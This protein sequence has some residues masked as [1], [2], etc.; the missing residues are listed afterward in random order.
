MK[1]FRLFL[2]VLLLVCLCAT[3][4]AAEPPFYTMT[5]DHDGEFVYSQAGYL[6]DLALYEFD[7]KPLKRPVDVFL[8]EE[9]NLF[10]ADNGNKRIIMC[11]RD[12]EYLRTYG[13]GL[14]KAPMG[15]CVR[16]GKLYVADESLKQ[17]VIFD[18]AS[19]DVIFELDKPEDLLYGQENNF[20]PQAVLVDNAG[21][22]YV[23]CKGNPNGIAQFSADGTFLC[24]FGAN[25]NKLTPMEML[26]RF[27]F[28]E[29]EA[30]RFSK[31]LS[32]S[33]VNM[34]MDER[35]MIY[36]VTGGYKG[37]KRL[38]M[39]GND[40]MPGTSQGFVG[41]T[42][43]A[44]GEYGNIFVIDQNG[45]I[46]EY[47]RDGRVLFYFAGQDAT[48]TRSG[49]FV[50]TVAIDIDS[51]G[52]LYV[53]DR[54]KGV[55]QRFAITEYARQV[56]HALSL[57]QDGLYEESREP[58]EDLLKQN[59]MFD[60]AQ[61]GLGRAYF[62]LEMYDEALTASRLGGDRNG[63]S[64]AFW[65]VRNTFLQD[66]IMWIFA[67]LIALWLLGKLWKLA[68]K[69]LTP[70]QKLSEAASRFAQTK[71]MREFGWMKMFLKNPADAL[72]GVKREQRVSVLS[73]TLLYL[74]FF[75]IYMVN[76]YTCG[77]LFKTVPDGYYEVGLDLAIVFGGIILFLVACNLICNIRD[78]EGTIKQMYCSM[79]YAFTPYLIL[80]P[81]AYALTFVLTQNEAFVI[82][83][84]DVVMIAWCVLLVLLM[85]RYLQEYSMWETLVT[86][87]LTAFTMLMLLIAMVIVIV[88][89][90]QLGDFITSVWKEARF[91]Y[92]S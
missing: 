77:F 90:G 86:I 9:D 30:T 58:W 74:L 49:L 46:M 43:V 52:C 89:V 73:A 18:L 45:Y 82:T 65:E 85:I 80:K 13:Q 22:M 21:S 44:V 91:F 41:A 75:L 38:S 66:N 62:Q 51:K 37:V 23:I 6:P 55:V 26:Q 2:T 68:R 4:Q 12:G 57:Y 20:R 76:K 54:D 10:I 28:S 19:G 24:Y 17:V 8:D 70:A 50:Y 15:V 84:L 59:S 40:T 83:L 14:L 32:S 64:D 67:G 53:A 79:A 7:G 47:T 11:T 36:T 81:I 92:E 33:P 39:S 27:L 56:H 3:A 1:K 29:E 35:G 71:R 25:V 5:E 16:H 78:G 69:H 34:A 63:Y 88:M 87:L 72:Y 61:M 31:N 60:Y 48:R 42:D